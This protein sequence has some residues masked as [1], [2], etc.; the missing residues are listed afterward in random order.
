MKLNKYLLI[1]PLALLLI[2]LAGTA[3]DEAAHSKY[4]PAI[5]KAW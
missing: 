3:P 2:S 4:Q 5:L 1:L